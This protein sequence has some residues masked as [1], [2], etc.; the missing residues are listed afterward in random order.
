MSGPAIMAILAAAAAAIVGGV[1][2]V[3]LAWRVHGRW[4]IYRAGPRR[5]WA[6]R[7]R[8]W[9]EPTA[10]DAADLRYGPGGPDSV[11]VPPFRFVEEHLAGS[12]PCVAVRDAHGRLWRVKWGHEARPESFA[13]R[14]AWACGYFAEVTHYVPAGVVE[15]AAQ[16]TRARAC[17]QEDGRFT[18]A[19]FELEDR[20]VRMF[21]DEHSW[22]WDDNPFVGTPQLS[23][24]KIVV[25]LLSNWDTKDRRDVSRGSN[26]AIFEHRVSRLAREARY[27]ITDWGGAMG[28]W[29]ANV[30]SRGR[31]DPEGFAAQTANF[32]TRAADGSVSFGYQGQRTAEI[33]RGIPPDHVAWF[34]RYARRLTPAALREGLL[35]CG[36]TDDEAARFADA[37]VDR[38][39]QLDAI[40]PATGTATQSQERFRVEPL[41]GRV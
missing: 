21:F 37:L 20:G 27:L 15:G 12:Q 18:D 36:A 1:V 32:V 6:T 17:L 16:L 31:W 35:A 8:I 10:A 22:S 11:P 34:C 5:L 7:H 40:G 19:R 3:R 33:A 38:I 26:T 29:G 9:R 24:L 25:M 13:V 14:F 28:K 41:K 4:K 2:L 30:V 39:R 23:G